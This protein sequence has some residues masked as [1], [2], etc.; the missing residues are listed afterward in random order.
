[1]YLSKIVLDIRHPSVRQAL[2]DV[3]DLHRNLMSGFEMDSET[4]TARARKQVLFRLCTRRD[5]AYLLVTSGEKPDAQALARRGFYVDEARTRDVSALKQVFLPGKLLQFELLASPCKKQSGSG[6][7]SRRLFLDTPGLREEWLKR[8]GAQGGF[9]VVHVAEMGGRVDICG[10]RGEMEI[11]NS[12]VL[13]SGL[14]RVEDQ[15]AFWQSYAGGIGP[16][17][18]Y[19]LGMLTLARA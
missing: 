19:G 10:R 1:M 18:A 2:W 9:Q 12:A 17:K 3:N 8:K 5:E 6:K 14:L 11:K 15:D 13:F 4:T 16:G 7:N